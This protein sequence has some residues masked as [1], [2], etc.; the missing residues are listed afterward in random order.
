MRILEKKIIAVF[1]LVVMSGLTG[2]GQACNASLFMK[3]GASLTYTNYD[4]K[5]K[6]TSKSVHET[7]AVLPIENGL[8]AQLKVTVFD[9]KDKEEFST[10]YGA[11][12]QNGVF[13]VDMVRFF[14]MNK[15]AEQEQED[16]DFDITG[17]VL[18]FPIDMKP[19]DRLENGDITIKLNSNNITLVT[20]SFLVF[21]RQVHTDETITTPAGTFDCQVVS[22]DFE[23]K[24][25][26]LKIKGTGKEW[27]LKDKVVVK[28]E[29]YNKKG[30]LIGYHELTSMK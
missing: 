19:G 29:S 16:L 23:S 6:K 17:S 22:F 13:E 8:D 27:Y 7:L 24:F 9:K 4:K 25:G 10:E 26:I 18:S 15:L 1:V 28:S 30:K 3:P 5:G 2:Y 11:K 20:M 14:D 12:C 21:N